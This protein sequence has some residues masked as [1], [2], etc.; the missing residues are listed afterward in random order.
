MGFLSGL[1]SDKK[2]TKSNSTQTGEQSYGLTPE[3]KSYWESISPQF[4][5]GWNPV[6]DNQYQT[7]AA[8]A[9][10]G[11]A[12]G[13]NPA[14]GTAVG[15]GQ[16]GIDPNLIAKFQ[17]PYQ[18][19]VID[20]TIGTI[21]DNAAMTGSQQEAAAAKA[22]ALGGTS[23]FNRRQIRDDSTDKLI[24]DTTA[25][26]NN[27]GFNTALG[28]ANQSTQAQLAG[29]GAASGIA[30]QQ[31]SINQGQ[32]GM[33]T[34]LWGQGWQNAVMP[35]TIGQ[36]G[37]GILSGL[38]GASGQ[39][40]SGTSQGTQTTTA[41]PS[42]FSTIMNLAG[43]ALSAGMFSDE[44]VKEDIIPIGE[45]F[46]GQPIY[47]F[48]YK[49]DPRRTIG[50]L[51]QDVEEHTPEAVGE[52][53]G[54]KTVDYEQALKGAERPGR[55]EGGA[56][57]AP[58][59][60]SDPHAKFKSAF[61]A[62]TGLISKARGGSVGAP[63]GLTP[64]GRSAGGPIG[65]WSTTVTPASSSSF[66]MKKFGQGLSKM[67]EQSGSGEHD[68]SLLHQQQQSLS[69]ML[70]G[71]SARRAIGGGVWDETGPEFG[72]SSGMTRASLGAAPDRV[73]RRPLA[74]VR[75]TWTG[76]DETWRGLSSTQRA[77]AMGLL[78]A[79]GRDPVAARNAV[80]AMVNRANRTGEDLGSHVSR[81]I[82]QP[83]IEPAQRARLASVVRSPEFK[84]LTQYAEDRVL[85][86]G[87]DPVSGATHFLASEKTMRDLQRKDPDTYHNW[88]P[89][90]NS[91]GVPGRNWTKYDPATG[92]YPNV[93]ARD[94]SHAFLSPEGRF[95]GGDPTRDLDENPG[96]LPPP[97]PSS[98]MVAASEAR[99]PVR[100]AES[101]PTSASATVAT[102]AP[103][104]SGWFSEGVWAGEKMT[105]MQR[106]GVG[107]MS[108]RGPMFGGPMNDMAKQLMGMEEGRLNEKR[109]D[110]QADQFAKQIA[111]QAAIAAGTINGQPT[112]EARRADATIAEADANRRIREAAV[113]G[114]Y[115][116]K[117]TVAGRAQESDLKTADLKRDI[118]E[119]ELDAKKNP[120]R[121]YERR[122]AVADKYGLTGDQR[123]QF[124]FDGK[125]P[126]RSAA[127]E[128]TETKEITKA[129]VEM[130]QKD[131]QSAKGAKES[132]GWVDELTK[133]AQDPGL[134]GA[135]GP[136]DQY[137]LTQ[138]IG[139]VLPFGIGGTSPD[140]SAKIQRIQQQ[141]TLAGGEKMKGLGA[142]SDAEGARLEKAVSN[143]TSARNKKEFL[144]S[145]QVIESSLVNSYNRAIDAAKRYPGLSSEFAK[146]PKRDLQARQE[147][148]DAIAAEKEKGRDIRE[149]VI[150]RLIE[151]GI[152]ATGI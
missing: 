137:S 48:N 145:L 80:S 122:A 144:D 52:V 54:I 43:T 140:L 42:P 94:K 45:S 25:N 18:K 39:S 99:A 56:V 132:I 116:G 131:I 50:L 30:G 7:A 81:A 135:I 59:G 108:V 91:K 142:Q 73:E 2:T 36:Q 125:I 149:Q 79:D 95:D 62:I 107:L 143:L 9:Q 83:T 90:P 40:T 61:E 63:S 14:F 110:S 17:S 78:E 47:E 130:A 93:I 146:L 100:V 1:F 96:P 133:I 92:Q 8:Q 27:Q 101:Q 148:R 24:A 71:M 97:A 82:Y 105:P 124:I 60:E 141:L 5:Q 117:P 22:G 10:A 150:K 6:A 136:L 89:F 76:E 139:S 28:A 98:T 32:F 34:G 66:D 12:S 3:V 51:A 151:N 57:G 44:R 87:Q 119:I 111:Q 109:I 38:A 104:R 49:G 112:V 86:R 23:N 115:D 31:S 120:D 106:L 113:T 26:L 19:Q 85:N 72:G 77:A 102:D 70:S 123:T 74:P 58:R 84:G 69:S 114:V 37:A 121:V 67:G 21:R 11:Y 35:Y 103:K 128:S 16:T 68:T 33:G 55:S 127:T 13:L 134:E 118:A 126:D 46:D 138:T 41:T 65:S 88:G 129:A 64:P 29:L 53:D 20:S 4:T 75:R 15:I 147:A 152:D